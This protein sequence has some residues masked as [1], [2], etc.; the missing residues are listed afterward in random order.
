M[1]RRGI[2][3]PL[4]ACLVVALLLAGCAF[5]PSATGSFERTLD[6][7]GP[8]RLELS[9]T[10]GDISIKG[11]SE[12]KVHIHAQVR[13]SGFGFE[14]PDKRLAELIATPPVEQR[15][16]TIRVGKD[17]AHLHN[18]TISYVIDVPHDTEISTT[19]VSGTET[20]RGVRG[21]V[22]V[23]AVSGSIHVDGVERD[24]E[25]STVSGSIEANNVHNDVRA[26]SASGA[27]S[28]SNVKGA[29]SA[30]ALSGSTLVT[31]PGGRVE[32]E[33][34]SGS[35]DVQGANSDV[36]ARAASGRITIRGNPA[37]NSYWDLKTASGTVQ[38]AVPPAA[39]FHL[40]AEAVSGEIRTDVPIV[41]EEQSK[42]SL[43][44]R[45]G[46]GGGRVEV[47]TVSGEI[48]IR[49]AS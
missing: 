27:V 34:A 19:V 12:K 28:V 21:P 36:K 15:D 22:K 18:V 33:T 4:L 7:S 31:N 43:R 10:A 5:G 2:L 39:N 35:I 20:V 45:M 3:A 25:L 30:K 40:S 37:G 16:D 48:Q 6:V 14:S 11:S 17:F 13:V 26:S 1:T 44:A 32:A 49:R 9:D 42:H 8:I 46:D 38:I 23:T 41:V 29:V 24:A 47:H